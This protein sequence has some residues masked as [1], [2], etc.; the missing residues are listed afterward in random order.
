MKKFLTL[1]N[2]QAKHL[3]MTQSLVIWVVI[4]LVFN[5]CFSVHLSKI[6][7][8]DGETQGIFTW[9]RVAEEALHHNPDLSQARFQVKSKVLSRNIAFGSY[10]PAADASFDRTYTKPVAAGPVK[11]SEKFNMGVTQPLFTGFKTTAEFLKAKKEWEAAKFAYMKTSA[12]VRFLLRSAFVE[13]LKQK[14]LLKV[15][16][17]IAGR[18][19]KNAELIHLRYEAGREHLGSDLRVQAILDQ[20]NF[21]VRQTSRKIESKSLLL[22]RQMGGKFMNPFLIEGNLEEMVQDLPDSKPDFLAIA[23]ETPQVKNLIK[24]A[25]SLKAAVVSAESSVYPQ[26]NGTYDYGYSGERFSNQ[27]D[28]S[29]VALKVSLPLFHGGRNIEAI[30]KAKAD[31][32]ATFEQARSARDQAVSDLADAWATF[33]DAKELVKVRQKFL[34]ASHKRAEIVKSEYETGLVNF[35]DFDT[36]EQEISDSERLYTQSLADA[37]VQEANW[38]FVRGATLED[39]AHVK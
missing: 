27:R 10:L 30:R 25:E 20:A 34:E 4:T 2:L 9:N 31:Y 21:E 29:S 23:E 26:V 37:L 3:C 6:Q 24:T 28:Q 39:F 36:T 14:R 17:N 11:D 1:R 12:N 38:N 18:R 8:M 5:G 22:G 16:Q 15:N 13:L 32:K 33:Q 35:Q 7:M 19:H